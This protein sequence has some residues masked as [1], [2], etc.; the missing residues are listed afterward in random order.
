MK[1]YGAS[2]I[3]TDISSVSIANNKT[4]LVYLQQNNTVGMTFIDTY[5]D[6]KSS[7]PNYDA[8]WPTILPSRRLSGTSFDLNSTVIY[9]YYQANDTSIAEISYDIINRTWVPNPTY[10]SII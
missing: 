1:S 6:I 10:V 3:G 4:A 8:S 9:V 7:F 5:P 2:S